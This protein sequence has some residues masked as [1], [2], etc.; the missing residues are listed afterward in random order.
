MAKMENGS[1][2]A[3]LL[4][5]TYER[6][7]ELAQKLKEEPL[8]VPTMNLTFELEYG[9]AE[10]GEKDENIFDGIQET[11]ESLK[12]RKLLSDSSQTSSVIHSLSQTLLESDYETEEHVLRTRD[13]AME[14]GGCMGLSDKDIGR[15][16]LLSIL[17]DIGKIA[18][19]QNILLK[20]GRLDAEEWE[21]MK[22]HTSKGYRIAKAS[23]ELEAIAELILHHH[24]KWDGTGYPS[25]LKGEEIPLLSRVITVVDSYDVMVHDRPYHKAISEAEAREELMQC[26]GTQFDPQIVEV[27]LELLKKKDTADA[28]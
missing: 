15:L 4:Q 12:N 17:H 22:T 24:E 8:S 19:P 2:L 1:F 10:I 9:L 16:A 25:G 14:L 26:A 13:A 28:T 11:M 6:A 23:P 18:I 5:T 3:V 27:Y 7:R 20:P 21:I